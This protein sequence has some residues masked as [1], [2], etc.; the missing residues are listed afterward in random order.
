VAVRSVPALSPC[1]AIG[2][3]GALRQRL[4]QGVGPRESIS[5]LQVLFDS[6]RRFF[7]DCL[8]LSAIMAHFR[9]LLHSILLFSGLR[10]I[11]SVH[12][13]TV[14]SLLHIDL[15]A[16]EGCGERAS[17]GLVAHRAI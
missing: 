17:D 2:A 10:N 7:R 15:E 11:S 1:I 4:V 16:V 8:T 9:L 5:L 3:V 13:A 14:T 12:I 6:L